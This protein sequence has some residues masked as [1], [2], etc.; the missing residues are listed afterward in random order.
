MRI[1]LLFLACSFLVAC[2]SGESSFQD[3]KSAFHEVKVDGQSFYFSY[4]SAAIV[5]GDEVQGNLDYQDCHV[6]FAVDF[7][8]DEP[9]F[10]SY[11]MPEVDYN[12]KQGEGMVYES[13]VSEGQVLAYVIFIEDQNYR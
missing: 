3:E 2:A 11:P 12:A 10:S 9:P 13:F 5:G 8:R 4:P 7:G 6:N 1:I